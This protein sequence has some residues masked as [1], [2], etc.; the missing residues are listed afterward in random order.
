VCPENSLW[1][2][3]G[4]QTPFFKMYIGPMFGSKTTHLL[5]DVDKLT[6]K[7]KIVKAFKPSKDT[8]YSESEILSH[9]GASCPATNITNGYD[10][11]NSVA[12]NLVHVV[13]VDEAFMVKGCADA[14]IK[15]YLESHISIIVSSIQL[16]ANLHP[17]HEIKEMLPWATS[18]KIC[19]AICTECDNDAFFTKAN[20]QI[21]KDPVLGG[22]ETYSPKCLKH[23]A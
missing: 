18:I 22:A 6:R 3:L 2:E 15:L 13:A 1:K 7:G 12:S 4:M 8:R 14:L 16:D 23:M 21:N 19:E 10:I 9:N 11:L 5:A 20:V 17:F